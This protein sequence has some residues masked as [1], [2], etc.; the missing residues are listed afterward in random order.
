M[1]THSSI[2]A[3]EISWTEES[4]RL[5]SGV[6]RVGRDFETKP[7]P[8]PHTLSTPVLPQF[9]L[10]NINLSSRQVGERL[11]R[12]GARERFKRERTYSYG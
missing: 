2:L 10:Q 7:P 4:G 5:Q 9:L 8:P 1:T 12:E 3:W 6:A 11:K